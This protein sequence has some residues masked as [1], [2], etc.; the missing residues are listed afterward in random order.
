LTLVAPATA[1]FR[2]DSAADD[3]LS[4]DTGTYKVVFLA[5]PL[6]AY[7]TAAQKA[8]LLTRVVNFFGP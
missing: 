1:V 3:G 2:D 4:V 6:E 5:F 8:D 7:G